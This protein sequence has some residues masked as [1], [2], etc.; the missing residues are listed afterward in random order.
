MCAFVAD[1]AARMLGDQGSQVRSLS[2][3]VNV[4]CPWGSN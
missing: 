2:Q 1:S 4:P 3:L